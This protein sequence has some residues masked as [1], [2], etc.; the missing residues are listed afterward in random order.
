MGGATT[1]ETP[2]RG[3]VRDENQ[4]PPIVAGDSD[5]QRKAVYGQLGPRDGHN[6]DFLFWKDIS[7]V[8]LVDGCSPPQWELRDL[9][10]RSH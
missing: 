3:A 5:P 9:W 10:D 8:C 2:V 7:K 4:I 1:V 6:S